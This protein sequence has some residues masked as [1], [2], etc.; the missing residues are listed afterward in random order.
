MSICAENPRSHISPS[1]KI[2]SEA[3][4]G[5]RRLHVVTGCHTGSHE[6]TESHMESQVFHQNTGNPGLHTQSHVA[7]EASQEA[8]HSYKEWPHRHPKTGMAPLLADQLC[9]QTELTQPE[10]PQT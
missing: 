6:V 5:H 10:A 8:P 3:T 9:Y 7:H 2:E 1:G 4:Q